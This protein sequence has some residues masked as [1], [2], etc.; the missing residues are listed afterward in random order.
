MALLADNRAELEEKMRKA[1]SNFGRVYA[2]INKD[3]ESV[4]YVRSTLQGLL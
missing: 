3:E 2:R 1:A 4:G